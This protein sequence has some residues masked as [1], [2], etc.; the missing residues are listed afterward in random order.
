MAAGCW[1]SVWANGRLC[2]PPVVLQ[3][4]T[5]L[6]VL[7]GWTP[8]FLRLLFLSGL[9]ELCWTPTSNSNAVLDLCPLRFGL[10]GSGLS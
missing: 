3:I 5:S 4:P 6:A 7:P 2:F 10:N 1:G 9:L 8:L